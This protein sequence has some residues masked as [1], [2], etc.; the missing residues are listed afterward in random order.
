MDLDSLG[1]RLV[2]PGFEDVET[3]ET[4]TVDA[5]GIRQDY[6]SEVA[7]FRKH[8]QEECAK[9]RI[10]FVPMDTSVGFD[11]ALLEYLIRR[12]RSG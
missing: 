8:F 10:D 5:K 4:L 2:H 12:Q 6:L 7:E 11:K 9:A 3:P 1:L